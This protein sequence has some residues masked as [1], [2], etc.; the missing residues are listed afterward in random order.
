MPTAERQERA[1]R[2]PRL[3]RGRPPARWLDAQ[4]RD[5]ERYRTR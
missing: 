3:A 1:R 4:L 5:L 2:L